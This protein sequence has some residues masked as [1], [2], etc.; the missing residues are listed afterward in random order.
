MNLKFEEMNAILEQDKNKE[1]AYEKA[2]EGYHFQVGRYNIWM[3]YYA[4]FVGALFVALYSVW[5]EQGEEGDR[6]L[7]LC[8]AVLGLVASVCWYGALLGYRT[9]NGH[10]VKRV[11]ELEREIGDFPSV[12][13][14]MPE[15]EP[16]K[17]YAKGFVSTQKVTGLFLIAV[18]IAWICVIVYLYGS[19]E[20]KDWVMWIIGIVFV[21]GIILLFLF[22][23]Y[24]C[25]LY[26]SK[27][28]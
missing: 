23:Y 20:Y 3:N 9:W 18:M 25:R 10:W 26:S 4:I 1:T 15:V 16:G 7:P 28:V 17:L 11:H 13:G 8:I 21:L 14:Y 24:G 5:S 27:I 19:M 12:Y 22:H 6:F 2:I